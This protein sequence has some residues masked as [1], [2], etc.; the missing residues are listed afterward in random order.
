MPTYEADPI[1]TSFSSG[2]IT[3]MQTQPDWVRVNYSVI[4][5]NV[6]TLPVDN[7][8]FMLKVAAYGD[9]PSTVNNDTAATEGVL[10]FAHITNTPGDTFDRLKVLQSLHPNPGSGLEQ[11]NVGQHVFSQA[12][13]DAFAAKHAAIISAGEYQFA[14]GD[15]LRF[16]LYVHLDADT[17]VQMRVEYQIF[18]TG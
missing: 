15:S 14:A 12:Q 4:L 11:G 13:M 6:T 1:L 8:G 10:G 17:S 5:P 16:H 9:T 3:L 2:D 18:I 7:L